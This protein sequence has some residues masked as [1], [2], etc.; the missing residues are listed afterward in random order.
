MDK[1][2]FDEMI[3][4]RRRLHTTPEEGWTEFETTWLIVSRLREI[5]YGKVLFG[6]QILNPDSVL[7]R[8]EALVKREIERAVADGVPASFIE[9][10]GGYTGAMAIL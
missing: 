4:T 10:A 3:A 2:L 1:R 9:E 6:R 5:G 8:N 7:G